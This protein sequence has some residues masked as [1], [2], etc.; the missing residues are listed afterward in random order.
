MDK[1]ILLN[2]ACAAA[3]FILGYLVKGSFDDDE[4]ETDAPAVNKPIGLPVP[5]GPRLVRDFPDMWPGVISGV[6]V[7]VILLLLG[8]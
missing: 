2:I 1:L 4:P 6:V 8:A 3:G 5:P 7:L